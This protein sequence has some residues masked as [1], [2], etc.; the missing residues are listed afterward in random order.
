MLKNLET[1]IP[2]YVRL[3]KEEAAKEAAKKPI[4]GA[5]KRK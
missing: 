2:R 4:R 3:D 1:G 5:P